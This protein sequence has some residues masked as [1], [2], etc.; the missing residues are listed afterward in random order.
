METQKEKALNWWIHE[1]SNDYWS[2]IAIQKFLTKKHF[3]DEKLHH[4]LTSNDIEKIYLNEVCGGITSQEERVGKILER[5]KLSVFGMDFKVLFERDKI[6]DNGRYYIQIEYEAPCTKTGKVETWKGRKWYLS[7]YM[8]DDEIVKTTWC[9]FE[10]CVKH[11]VM[12]G[13]KVDDIILF[14]PHVNFE[15]LLKVSHNEVTRD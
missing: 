4:K 5:I 14:N 11:E 1:L 6:I 10:A 2:L 3:G 9:A 13:F 8:T 7:E 15:E 12:E